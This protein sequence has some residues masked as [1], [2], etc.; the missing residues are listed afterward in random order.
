MLNNVLNNSPLSIK[1][2]YENFDYFLTLK[3]ET[4]Y[5]DCIVK[6]AF[7]SNNINLIHNV[8]NILFNN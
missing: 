2:L 4:K 3:E 8:F 6:Y 7:D 1:I 5:F